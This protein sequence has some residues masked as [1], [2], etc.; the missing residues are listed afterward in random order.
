MYQRLHITPLLSPWL[1]IWG[2]TL[3]AYQVFD[4]QPF[5][6][7][8]LLTPRKTD[9][10]DKPWNDGSIAAGAGQ[11]RGMTVMQQVRRQS[12]A[13]QTEKCRRSAFFARPATQFGSTA[14]FSVAGQ[15]YFADLL[16]RTARPA[17]VRGLTC[18]GTASDLRRARRI[19][20]YRKVIRSECGG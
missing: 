20:T 17:T 9:S 14:A 3:Q 8:Q 12:D 5:P 1:F 19:H 15:R 16:H 4:F 2:L 18:S 7:S 10:M 6:I 13:G 11:G